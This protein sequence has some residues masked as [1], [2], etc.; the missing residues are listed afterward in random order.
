MIDAQTASLGLCREA[1]DSLADRRRLLFV[2][3]NAFSDGGRPQRQERRSVARDVYQG[4]SR[5]EHSR[6][7]FEGWDMGVDGTRGRGGRMGRA[8]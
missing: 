4:R 5:R 6:V 2:E 1:G 7:G 8:N 3:S